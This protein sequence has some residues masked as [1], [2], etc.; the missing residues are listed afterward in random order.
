MWQLLRSVQLCETP[1]TVAHKVPL[2]MKFS[3]QDYFSGLPCPPQGIF[4]TQG[5]NSH[6]LHCR[7][8]LYHLNHQ[9]K[10][11]QL[12]KAANYKEISDK[13]NLKDIK[14]NDSFVSFRIVKSMSQKSR[15][16]L[17]NTPDWRRHKNS[18]QYMILGLN[19]FAVNDIIE[20]TEEIWKGCI[21]ETVVIRQW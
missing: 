13:P 6:L 21:N 18:I 12:C 14:K 5:S 19:P 3:R 10:E 9:T 15:R 8:I 20:T 1:W 17:G 11:A 16:D 7:Q 2:S 4:L